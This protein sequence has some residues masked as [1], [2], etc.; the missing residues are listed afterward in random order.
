MIIQLIQS[1]KSNG[2]Q[3]NYK[4]FNDDFDV[5]YR[6]TD[7]NG[8]PQMKI[9]DVFKRV[10]QGLVLDIT[11]ME[12]SGGGKYPVY[13]VVKGTPAL[14]TEDICTQIPDFHENFEDHIA[15]LRKNMVV[16]YA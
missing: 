6:V 3:M 13:L 5:L 16:F 2:V 12:A 10:K 9:E 8:H 15:S 14:L 1:T 7:K 4:R 11:E